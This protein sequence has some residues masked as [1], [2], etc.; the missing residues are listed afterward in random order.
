[1]TRDRNRPDIVGSALRRAKESPAEGEFG[2]NSGSLRIFLDILRIAL[3]VLLGAGHGMVTCAQ[4]GSG[5]RKDHQD[6][7]K[8]G[9]YRK[10][11]FNPLRKLYHRARNASVHVATDGVE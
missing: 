1:M 7:Q 10:H 4:R 2:I 6:Q 3:N 5:A 8:P 9:H 11:R